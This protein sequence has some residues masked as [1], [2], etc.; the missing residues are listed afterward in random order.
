MGTK[1]VG[2]D[3]HVAAGR[4]GIAAGDI[5]LLVLAPLDAFGRID[6]NRILAAGERAGVL[7]RGWHESG[8]GQHHGRHRSP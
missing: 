1:L 2:L 7:R 8:C 6:R 4:L 5:D 3:R